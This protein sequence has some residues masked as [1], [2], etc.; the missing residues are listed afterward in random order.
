MQ[1]SLDATRWRIL[2][3]VDRPLPRQRFTIAHEFGHFALHRNLQTHFECSNDD[4]AGDSE[5]D[6]QLEAAQFAS[7]ILMPLDDLRANA[8]A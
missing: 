1:C 7:A 5:R 4:V 6:I 3:G 2:Y 8:R